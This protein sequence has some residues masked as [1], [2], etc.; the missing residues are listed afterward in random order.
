VKREQI[1]L[2][3]ERTGRKICQSRKNRDAILF[4]DNHD[5]ID[6]RLLAGVQVNVVG[7]AGERYLVGAGYVEAKLA[8]AE[9]SAGLRPA[10]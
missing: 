8:Q 1:G 10:I 7:E 4:D 3:P 2:G 5:G 9:I 6:R